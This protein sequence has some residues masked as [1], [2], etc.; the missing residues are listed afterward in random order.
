MLYR[1]SRLYLETYVYTSM[2]IRRQI[3]LM[4][5]DTMNLRKKR[6]YGSAW[7]EGRKREM[8]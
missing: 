2:Y 1:L 6:V 8:L 5:E 3:Q 4:K 7:S